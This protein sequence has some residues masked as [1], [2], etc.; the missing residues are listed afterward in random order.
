MNSLYIWGAIFVLALVVEVATAGLAT[1][2]FAGGALVAFILRVLEVPDSL[3]GAN[4]VS[5][6]SG[7]FSGSEAEVLILPRTLS[8]LPGGA[9]AG[10]EKLGK[11]AL[12]AQRLPEVGD[13]LLEGAADGLAIFV[14]DGLYASYTTDYFWGLYAAHIRALGSLSEGGAG[15]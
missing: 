1:I 2:W 15:A 11:A 6:A 12:M 14:P 7:A 5:V 3:G 8:R 4:V 10:M 13:A 9:F